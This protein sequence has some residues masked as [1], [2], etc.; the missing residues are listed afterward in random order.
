MGNEI[1]LELKEYF[2]V[3]LEAED[4][5]R[6]MIEGMLNGSEFLMRDV[7]HVHTFGRNP[8]MTSGTSDANPAPAR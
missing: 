7:A 6:A 8:R 3:R 2:V 5:A 1:L 4:F